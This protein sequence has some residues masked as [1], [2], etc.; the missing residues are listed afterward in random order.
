MNSSSVQS[1]VI[2]VDVVKQILTEFEHQSKLR[3]LMIFERIVCWFL[4]LLAFVF[5]FSAEIVDFIM[6]FMLFIEKTNLKKQRNTLEKREEFISIS[7]SNDYAFWNVKSL[8][9]IWLFDIVSVVPVET[10]ELGSRESHCD[11]IWSDI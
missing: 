10:L 8:R 5:T 1:L 2:F 6:F 7:L 3:C 9:F 4:K 11:N